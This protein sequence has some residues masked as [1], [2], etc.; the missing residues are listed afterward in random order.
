MDHFARTDVAYEQIELLLQQQK[1][2]EALPILSSLIEKNPSDRQARLC[3]LLVVRILILRR[4][5]G[6][7][8]IGLSARAAAIAACVRVPMFLAFRLQTEFQL[9]ARRRTALYSFPVRLNK[10]RL[11]IAARLPV[12]RPW[13]LNFRDRDQFEFIPRLLN[14]IAFLAPQGKRHIAVAVA[15]PV[16][17]TVLVSVCVLVA[18]PVENRRLTA[19][20]AAPDSASPETLATAKP[21]PFDQNPNK[22]SIVRSANLALDHSGFNEVLPKSDN[23]NRWLLD[24]EDGAPS[25][26]SA[27][28]IAPRLEVKGHTNENQVTGLGKVDNDHNVPEAV[29]K[30]IDASER[31]PSSNE[32]KS[33]I[34]DAPKKI[35]AQYQAKQV[36]P[37]RTSAR[38][39]APTIGTISKGTPVDVSGVNN[40]WAEVTLKN[41]ANDNVTGFVRMEFLVPKAAGAL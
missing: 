14:S 28:N 10:Y 2:D 19:K 20:R 16:V 29:A 22:P 37:I 9:F 23:L 1:Y 21:Q 30:R 13:S 33:R 24:F 15:V 34:V 35:I 12:H 6:T 38:F 25:L 5:L 32:H 17:V 27:Q 26:N 36:I 8:K 4:F 3:R 11:A 31:R 18:W 7:Q 40:S 39:G 41:D